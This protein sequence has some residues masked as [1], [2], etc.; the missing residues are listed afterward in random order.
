[1]MN[2]L[3]R[4]ARAEARLFLR[5]PIVLI[6]VF[7]FPVITVLVLGGVFNKSDTAFEGAVP[8]DYYVAGYIGVVLAAIGLIM[9]PVHLASYRERGVLRRFRTSQFASW[10][11]P[12]AWAAV[13]LVLSII[14]I[15]V[16]LVAGAVVYGLPAP[17]DMARTLTG[18]ALA[19]LTFISI[20]ILLGTVLP[21]ARS[22]QG[23]GLMLFFPLFLLGGGGPP[24]QAMSNVMRRISNLLPLTHA[25]RA[26]QQPWL[27]IGG[28][29]TNHLIVLTALFLT[30]TSTWIYLTTR[31]PRH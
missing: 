7:A 27:S 11:L 23:L 8:S 28:S 3:T 21:T 22:A 19:T 2:S 6:F 29:S 12:V 24:P 15:A 14:A 17:P 20:G 26:I 18:I 16:R 9:L 10:A 30:T 1:M 25:I 5:E 4:L 31:A 13:A